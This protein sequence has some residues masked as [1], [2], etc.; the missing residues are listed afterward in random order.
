MT[1]RADDTQPQVTLELGEAGEDDHE[2]VES[3]P[4]RRRALASA[5]IV[6]LVFG[7]GVAVGSHLDN[8]RQ[9]PAA[10]PKP[11]QSQP[12]V[13]SSTVARCSAQQGNQLQLGIEVV[14][15]G[16]STVTLHGAAV[17]LPIGG[18]RHMA[19]AWGPCGQVTEPPAEAERPLA[20]G[21]TTWISATFEVL[22]ECPAPYPV[23][24]VVLYT[25]AESAHA[26]AAS[27]E[28]G[29]FNDLGDVPYTGCESPP[30]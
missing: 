23:R 26:T 2:V 11:S 12:L 24:F 21:A 4:N 25:G 18:L 27:A 15:L 13:V 7:L 1:D 22:D 3:R 8:P 9:P 30:A 6:A 20:S 17:D 19:T 16:P 5:A 29:G 14:N 28:V 10:T